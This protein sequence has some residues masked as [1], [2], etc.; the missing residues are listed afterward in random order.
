MLIDYLIR[1]AGRTNPTVALKVRNLSDPEGELVTL[2]A[3]VDEVTEDHILGTVTWASDTEVAAL[4]LNRR[5]NK[6]VLLICN[7]DTG[8]CKK[9]TINIILNGLTDSSQEHS[10]TEWN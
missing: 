9:V 10:P 5:Q 8:A 1:Q 2:L 7:A 4:W 3:P 6:S